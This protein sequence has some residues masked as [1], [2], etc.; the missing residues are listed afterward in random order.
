MPS[1]PPLSRF[2]CFPG[3]QVSPHFPITPRAAIRCC[4]PAM[5]LIERRAI[6]MRL[7]GAN[8]S[9]PASLSH[10]AAA[11]A[12]SVCVIGDIADYGVVVAAAGR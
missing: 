2:F 3:R 6:F 12:R 4:L 9:M 7:I 5:M 8:I 11:Y 10:I 1:L